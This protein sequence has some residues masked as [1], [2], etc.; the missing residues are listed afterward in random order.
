MAEA[1]ARK[2][3]EEQGISDR[4]RVMSAGTAAWQGSCASPEAVNV[5]KSK[6]IDLTRHRAQMLTR[7]LAGEADLILTMTRSH[8]NQ[9][10]LMM[11]S[12]SERTFTLRNTF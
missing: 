11:P 1:L 9:V 8:K 7:E 12:L 6:G 3:L 4:L 2:Y 5:M 10:I